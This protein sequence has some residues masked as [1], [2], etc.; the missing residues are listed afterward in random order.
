MA[1]GPAG[2]GAALPAD[3]AP[4]ASVTLEL[5][6]ADAFGPAAELTQG[7]AIAVTAGDGPPAL[8]PLPFT[9]RRRS[10]RATPGWSPSPR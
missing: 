2:G 7:S 6:F 1:R 8:L 4:G 5:G 10:G 3:L 9:A